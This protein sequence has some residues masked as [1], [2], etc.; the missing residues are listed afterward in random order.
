M[1]TF[2]FQSS[3]YFWYF[4]IS[5]GNMIKIIAIESCTF[6]KSDNVMG[7][8][9]M[10]KFIQ[11]FEKRLVDFDAHRSKKANLFHKKIIYLRKKTCLYR[12]N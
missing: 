10:E 8:L 2:P 7:N 5:I 9:K 12:V 6:S 1:S 11:C 4:C 3:G